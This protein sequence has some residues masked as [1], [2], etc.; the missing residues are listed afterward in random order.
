MI[1]WNYLK[2][3]VSVQNFE[4]LHVANKIRNRHVYFSN[5]KMKVNLVSQALSNTVVDAL[6][7]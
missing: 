1:T 6:T 4:K 5:E 3:L 2:E 7:F